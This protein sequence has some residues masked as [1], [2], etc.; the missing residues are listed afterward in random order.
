MGSLIPDRIEKRFSQIT[1]EELAAKGIR[2]VLADLDNTLTRYRQPDPGEEVKAW[3]DQLWQEGITLFVVSN[4]RRP[5][6]AQRFCD[7]LAVPHISHAGKPHRAA[8]LE[9]M[10]QCGC[11][12]EETVMLGDQIF[13]D[14]WGAHNA[15]IPAIYIRPIALDS[16]FRK[17]R[18]GI[19]APLRG[20]CRLRGDRI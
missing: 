8:F 6:R 17:L 2:L 1:A 13:T 10:G 4:G 15:G 3:R 9:A 11:R 19:E 20:L 14:I 18:Y 5:Q 7:G 16:F 12:A